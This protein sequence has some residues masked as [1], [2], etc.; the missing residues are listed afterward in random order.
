MDEEKEEERNRLNDYKEKNNFH[1]R[2]FALK[3]YSLESKHHD[4]LINV[5]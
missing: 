2:N 4:V 5:V 1:S 3:Q